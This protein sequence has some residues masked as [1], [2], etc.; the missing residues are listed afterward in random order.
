MARPRQDLCRR[1]H[2]YTV[3]PNGRRDCDECQKLRNSKEWQA[4]HM[5]VLHPKKT[6]ARILDLLETD[7]GWL[8]VDG[9]C[10]HLGVT[11]ETAQKA[12]E[13]LRNSGF[14]AMREFPLAG[15]DIRYEWRM[16]A[17]AYAV[18]A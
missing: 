6:P 10:L 5:P 18:V 11:G 16:T 13:R 12:L 3:R 4:T 14:V 17:E 2:E 15:Y 1:G 9:I 8:T 7:R